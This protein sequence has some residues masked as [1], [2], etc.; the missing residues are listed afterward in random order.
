MTPQPTTP[1]TPGAAVAATTD[2]PHRPGTQG[3]TPLQPTANPDHATTPGTPRGDR[4][5]LAAAG[6]LVAAVAVLA[7]LVSFDA[8]STHA[9]A[10]GAFPP[11]LGWAAPLLVDTFTVAATL[12][13]YARS[14]AGIRAPFAWAY[15][16]AS[17]L[18]SLLLNI[19]HAPDHLDA[20]LI[21]ALP[22][23]AQ[24]AAIELLMSEAR[25]L[26][27]P[28]PPAALPT[29]PEPAAGQQAERTAAAD[30]QSPAAARTPDTRERIAELLTAAQ[31]RGTT[32][33][34]PQAAA[35]TGV[36]V[37]RAQQVLQQLRM[38]TDLP[39]GPTTA[40]KADADNASKDGAGAED[41]AGAA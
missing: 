23:L 9:V 36:S 7:F 29:W 40:P 19:A 32:V 25:R 22:P 21:A 41:R 16:A 11:A 38:Q 6:A 5:V 31:V 30:R 4:L 1:S 15:V 12:V 39:P 2:P 33:T 10:T 17:T 8:I 28:T 13:V 27:R 35:A 34:G 37:R 24:L 20:Q 26:T 14:R 18:A 3:A